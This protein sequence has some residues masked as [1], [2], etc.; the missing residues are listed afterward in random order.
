MGGSH[1]SVLRKRRHMG[2]LRHRKPQRPHHS[3]YIQTQSCPH[4]EIAGVRGKVEHQTR[5]G[6]PN[7]E[8]HLETKINVHYPSG[9]NPNCETSTQEPLGGTTRRMWPHDVRSN[10]MP[11]ARIS[12]T[13]LGMPDHQQRVLAAT[14][15]T[16]T[17]H[18]T[19]GGKH[20]DILYW[21]TGTMS[22]GKQTA[23]YAT[24]YYGVY[25]RGE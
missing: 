2:L 17:F 24:A 3:K 21:I 1:R 25:R 19:A 4:D 20:S 22:D 16:H 15:P 14:E 7:M 5:Q 23:S 18:R 10:G 9:L 13:S 8:R 6:R 12:A 11:A